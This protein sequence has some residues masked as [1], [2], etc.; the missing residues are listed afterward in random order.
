[1][2]TLDENNFFRFKSWS[3]FHRS[4]DR[5]LALGFVSQ[6]T[7]PPGRVLL[8]MVREGGLLETSPDKSLNLFACI[9]NDGPFSG[10]KLVN[11]GEA[12]A[13]VAAASAVGLHV[14]D[15]FIFESGQVFL[16]GE[17]DKEARIVEVRLSG[18]LNS[19]SQ[20][21]FEAWSTI[22]RPKLLFSDHGELRISQ[23]DRGRKHLS[24]KVLSTKKDPFVLAIAADPP[25]ARGG[26][27]RSTPFVPTVIVRDGPTIVDRN[28]TGIATTLESLGLPRKASSVLSWAEESKKLAELYLEEH[29][30][31]AAQSLLIRKDKKTGWELGAKG[32]E[33]LKEQYRDRWWLTVEREPDGRSRR[34]LMRCLP[35]MDIK[36]AI[37]DDGRFLIDETRNLDTEHTRRLRLALEEKQVGF[38]FIEHEK[39]K[40]R[41]R[42]DNRLT[43]L[44]AIRDG[45]E[46]LF[47]LLAKFGKDGLNPIEI[48]M[49]RLRFVLSCH[50]VEDVN[51]PARV[52][53]ALKALENL[54][55][56]INVK[57][58]SP[59][60]GP[61]LQYV[62]ENL[63]GPGSPT[64]GTFTIG[65][66]VMAIGGLRV[67]EKTGGVFDFR[68]KLTKENVA[69]VTEEPFR[70][71]PSWNGHLFASVLGL[72]KEQKRLSRWIE[73]NVTK[74]GDDTRKGREECKRPKD[75]SPR[76]Y[77]HDFCELLPEGSAF[78]GAL[79]SFKSNANGGAE[80]GRRLAQ[81]P[82]LASADGKS[83]GREGG[84]LHQMGI[85]LP[86]GPDP[87]GTRQAK[88]LEK[89]LPLLRSLVEG[90]YGGVVA[91]KH[92]ERWYGLSNA[93]ASLSQ[94]D[95]LYRATF[96]LFLPPDW[97]DR[98]LER[99]NEQT[100]SEAKAGEVRTRLMVIAETAPPMPEEQSFKERLRD[101]LQRRKMSQA[102]L[103]KV[104]GVSAMTVSK[105]VQGSLPRMEI[106]QALEQWLLEIPSLQESPQEGGSP[107]NH[108]NGGGS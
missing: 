85:D 90:Y 94:E 63:A 83:G 23:D 99:F 12:G 31:S 55:I 39:D 32:R 35:G 46:V 82:S 70:R 66:G 44:Q 50:R 36:M 58:G 28:S 21:P 16:E 78:V 65:L 7:R 74:N 106:R 61:F 57:E 62:K 54:R 15:G 11:V 79:G 89:A 98:L 43:N 105:W 19:T 97:R 67:F 51:G 84:L 34:Y 93:Q 60:S 45:I 53:G 20:A 3:W 68:K 72:S 26:K 88:V 37:Y 75:S 48:D 59:A 30:E 64:E 100:L 101:A 102:D 5:R 38:S 56:A 40:E 103:A 4:R 25:G 42:L 96:F 49:I 24:A 80:Q 52:R 86:R 91:V 13:I 41:E 9:L 77:S 1:M 29:G 69:T 87:R 8:G 95:L 107:K 33:R 47:D 6:K 104:F 92:R 71:L 14:P 17:S 73:S 76:I 81:L 10:R 22:G 27:P 108:E 2:T 18:F